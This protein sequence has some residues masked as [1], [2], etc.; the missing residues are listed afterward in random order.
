MSAVANEKQI[1]KPIQENAKKFTAKEQAHFRKTFLA[2]LISVEVVFD[3]YEFAIK[4][5]G[6]LCWRHQ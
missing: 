4:M 3:K 5:L 6:V 2:V 1:N